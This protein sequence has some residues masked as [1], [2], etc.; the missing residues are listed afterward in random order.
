MQDAL[1]GA[2]KRHPTWGPRKLRAWLV[3]RYPQTQF[4]AASTIGDV[5]AHTVAGLKYDFQAVGDFELAQVGPDFEVQARHVSGAPTWPNA[6][7]N[8]AIG[9]RMG[10]TRVTVC[11]GPRLVVNGRGVRL[12]DGATVSL[13]SGVDITL[14]GGVYVVTDRSGNSVR[15][16]TPSPRRW[17]R[18]AILRI[19]FWRRRTG[20]RGVW[21]C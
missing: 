7:V 1:V 5:H 8:Q 12:S 17:P 14:T 9:T 16:R 20:V 4:P 19:N 11:S 3:D 18:S 2:R 10:N 6:S 13:P 15:V 21:I